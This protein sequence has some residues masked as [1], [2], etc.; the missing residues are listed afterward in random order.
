MEVYT[1]LD[2][3][4]PQYDLRLKCI[5]SWKKYLP[6]HNLHILE[7]IQDAP[8]KYKTNHYNIIKKC[9]NDPR[10]LTD[11]LRISIPYVDNVKEYLYMD[12]DM[13][14]VEPF[15]E[16]LFEKKWFKRDAGTSFLWVKNPED[17]KDIYNCYKNCQPE[18]VIWDD[19][20]PKTD[21]EQLITFGKA[22]PIEPSI[23]DHIKHLHLPYKPP[24]CIIFDNYFQ[25]IWKGRVVDTKFRND[26]MNHFKIH[27]YP[28][29]LIKEG[30]CIRSID[31]DIRLAKKQYD[32]AKEHYQNENN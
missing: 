14:L 7:N 16:A 3:F 18:S 11:S 17:L 10:F 1:F 13:L 2:K 4:T 5:E 12:A 15:E 20:Q 9:S 32:K 23:K 29:P 27:H 8:E 26:I 30:W 6:N 19:G 31:Y 22:I 21:K 28:S 24:F 25:E